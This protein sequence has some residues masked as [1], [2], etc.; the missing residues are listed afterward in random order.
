MSKVAPI[1]VQEKNAAA[2]LDLTIKLFRSL[3]EKGSLPPPHRVD[4]VELWRVADFDAII[5]G[6]SI[7][8]RDD[9]QW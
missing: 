8:N 1:F 7:D 5:S 9:Y 3:V 4:E 2:I 6:R